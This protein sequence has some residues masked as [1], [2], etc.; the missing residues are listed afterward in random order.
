[1]VKEIYVAC[2]YVRGG[3]GGG[4]ER[5]RREEEKGRVERRGWD[6]KSTD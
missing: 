2:V 4:R 3:G 6:R 1:M 5:E